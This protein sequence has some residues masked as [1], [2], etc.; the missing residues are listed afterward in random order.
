VEKIRRLGEQLA[1][2]RTP[3]SAE[4][5]DIAAEILVTDY[6]EIILPRMPKH[7]G[8]LITFPVTAN[9]RHPA[10]TGS[11]GII[12]DACRIVKR[13]ETIENGE[14]G[15]VKKLGLSVMN[16]WERGADGVW[17]CL[18]LLPTVPTAQAKALMQ[19]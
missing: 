5:P 13:G 16:V 3:G 4:I 12:F 14:K 15:A 8:S 9:R 18:A 1:S 7:G 10:I 2:V 11:Y 6:V 19:F 17:K